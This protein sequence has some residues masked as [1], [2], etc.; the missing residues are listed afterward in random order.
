MAGTRSS[1]M[2]L[3]IAALIVVVAVSVVQSAKE[4]T[5]PSSSASF[6]GSVVWQG[7]DHE[8]LREAGS[9]LETPHRMG[10][11]SSTLENTTATGGAG[12]A[13][14]A[15]VVTSSSNIT[16][17]PGYSPDWAT[18]SVYYT[19]VVDQ[20][21]PPVV[22]LGEGAVVWQFA[23]MAAPLDDWNPTANTSLKYHLA[24]DLNTENL[25]WGSFDSYDVVMRGININ[26]RCDPD[27]QPPGYSCHSDAMWPFHLFMGFENCQR[28]QS[29][30]FECDAIL[31]IG[32]AWTPDHGLGKDFDY[33][34]HFLLN[35]LFTKK[36]FQSHLC[37]YSL[38]HLHWRQCRTLQECGCTTCEFLFY[39]SEGSRKWEW[40]CI[41]SR[42]PTSCDGLKKLWVYSSS[43]QV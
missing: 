41:Q 10:R 12:G 39:Y 15:V 3:A 26:I 6:G 4:A 11:F 8:W 17:A 29:S 38:L 34:H 18:P 23:D 16:F 35:N 37:C 19:A 25:G 40:K 20:N 9:T 32:R 7:F 1:P 36:F 27:T 22:G 30:L 42:I 14:A 33:R 31:E 24:V 2:A 13:A 28:T 21:D 43:H 5:A